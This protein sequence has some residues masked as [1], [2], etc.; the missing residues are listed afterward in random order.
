M[1]YLFVLPD[2]TQKYIETISQP[3]RDESGAVVRLMG[4]VMDVTERHQAEENLRASESLARGQMQALT[5]T[6]DA[7]AQES[8]PER[9][10]EHVLATIIEQLDAYNI[11]VWQR[12]ESNSLV[13]FEYTRENARLQTQH[14]APA[15]LFLAAEQSPPWQEVV[16]T[17]RCTVCEDVA[18][19]TYLPSRE[20]LVAQ[21]IVTVLLVPM[22]IAGEVVGLVGV[23]FKRKRAFRAEETELAQALVHQATRAM[24]LTRLSEQSRE[25]AVVAERNRLARDIHDTLAQG[26]TGVVVQLEAAEDAI[27][28]GLAQAADDHI[29]RAGGMARYGLSEARRSVQALRPQLLE[30]SELCS[31]L[32]GLIQKMSAGT[33]L[34]AE[35]AS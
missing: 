6:L 8:A 12:D 21:G 32:D 19:A 15:R 29:A 18:E 22:L 30:E 35:F 24:Q 26:F 16:R 10:L 25:A 33:S 28:K 14:Q 31:A 34:Q 1:Q 4:T 7:M 2:G 5:R 11:S 13:G 20:R 27:S 9:F 23:R 3:V 17:G